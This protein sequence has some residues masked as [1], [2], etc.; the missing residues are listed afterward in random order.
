VRLTGGPDPILPTYAYVLRTS[1]ELRTTNVIARD[2]KYE[3]CIP[4][5]VRSNCLSHHPI[6]L[7]T[8]ITEMPRSRSSIR[9]KNDISEQSI[10]SPWKARAPTQ[11]VV[12]STVRGSTSWM[13]DPAYTGKCTCRFKFHDGHWRSGEHA[14]EDAED[15][16]ERA[17]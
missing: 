3:T 11:A 5:S 2:E 13:S 16:S 6:V 14:C 7:R 17:T 4:Y 10:R 15:E 1:Y 12:Q 9:E 8:W